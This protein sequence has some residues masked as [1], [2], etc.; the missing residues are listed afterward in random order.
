MW[1]VKF[2]VNPLNFCFNQNLKNLGT[3]LGFT[4]LFSQNARHTGR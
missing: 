3:K 2:Q 1:L 4:T